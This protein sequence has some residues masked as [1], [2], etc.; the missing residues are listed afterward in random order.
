MYA[1]TVTVGITCGL[2]RDVPEYHRVVWG[3]GTYVVWMVVCGMGVGGG[4]GDIGSETLNSLRN[5]P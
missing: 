4:G 2:E 3:D 1:Y 5:S